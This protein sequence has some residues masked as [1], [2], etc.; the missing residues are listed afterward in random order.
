MLW[1]EEEKNAIRLQVFRSDVHD[2]GSFTQGNAG[3]VRGRFQIGSFYLKPAGKVIGCQLRMGLWDATL[4]GCITSDKGRIVLEHFTHSNDILISTTIKP[5]SGEEGCQWT[6]E[7]AR[8]TTTRKVDIRSTEEEL[9]QLR[10]ERNSRGKWFTELYDPEAHPQVDLSQIK[11]VNVCHQKLSHGGEHSTA[12]QEIDEGQQRRLL[13]SIVKKYPDDSDSSASEAAS[14]I[15]AIADRSLDDKLTW[16]QEHNQWWHNYYQRS[17]LSLN[18]TRAETLYWTQI[19]KMACST[20]MDRPMMDT[21]GIWQTPS[22]WPYITW[23]LNVQLCYLLPV[24]SNHI[25]TIGM[26]LINHLNKWQD[27]LIKNVEPETWQEDS[28]FV[29]V[30]TAMD[31]YMPRFVDGRDFSAE[32]GAHLTWVMHNCYQMYEATQDKEMLREKIF[33]L[34]RRSVNYQFH[35]LHQWPD[36]SYGFV[37]TSLPEMGQD[38]NSNY[39]LAIFRWGCQALL[40]SCEILNIHDPLI[41]KWKETLNKLVDFPYDEECGFR[42]GDKRVFDKAHRHPSHLFMI[43]PFH[44]TNITQPGEFERM[45]KSINRFYDV[46]HK[47]YQQGGDWEVLTGFTLTL[48]SL[49]SSTIGKGDEALKHLN[50]FIDYNTDI[51]YPN[52][53]YGESG[54]C[55]ESPLSAAQAILEMLIQSWGDTI[56]IFPATP[57]QWTDISFENIRAKGAFLVSASRKDGITQFVKIKSLAG[58]DCKIKLDYKPHVSEKIKGLGG[59]V[60]KLAISKGDEIVISNA[61]IE[62]LNTEIKAVKPQKEKCNWYGLNQSKNRSEMM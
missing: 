46:N 43:Y 44:Q 57:K 32:T 11:G 23:D 4:K 39:E 52:G 34:L 59:G 12:W 47:A 26:S 17:F 29:S 53:L 27:N 55:L 10:Q 25:E 16:Q 33:P 56:G 6:W 14:N 38:D 54:P 21:A 60:Y 51:V 15:S 30:C 1:Y 62:N 9:K 31:C 5:D 40:D 45:E 2:H 42:L 24:T 19:Y 37:N 49:M 61:T 18:D 20:R 13:I 35:I 50:S 22:P 8:A 58:Q 48:L 28:A 41:P 3:T 36:G 7:P